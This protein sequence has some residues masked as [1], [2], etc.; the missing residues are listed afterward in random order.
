[1]I[2]LT[3]RLVVFAM[4]N[5][6][7]GW[8]YLPA[9]P[10]MGDAIFTREDPVK[11]VPPT[12]RNNV[13]TW[14]LCNDILDDPTQTSWSALV[15][16]LGCNP[17]FASNLNAVNFCTVDHHNTAFYDNA[18]AA[19]QNKGS[20]T[21]GKCAEK[22][23]VDWLEACV[24]SKCNPARAK[25][26]TSSCPL[27]REAVRAQ[28][29]MEKEKM[30]VL[31]RVQSFKPPNVQQSVNA[32]GEVQSYKES[33]SNFELPDVRDNELTGKNVNLCPPE[34]MAEK[35]LA[36]SGA[37]KKTCLILADAMYMAVEIIPQ[38]TNTVRVKLH[39]FTNVPMAAI[40][41]E[42]VGLKPE[43]S[44]NLHLSAIMGEVTGL[45]AIKVQVWPEQFVSLKVT[46]IFSHKEMLCRSLKNTGDSIK[47]CAV[48][49]PPSGTNTEY[50]LSLNLF[51]QDETSYKLPIAS[52]DPTS[53]VLAVA[54]GPRFESEF[55]SIANLLEEGYNDD[56]SPLAG[57]GKFCAKIITGAFCDF[58]GGDTAC[59]PFRNAQCMQGEMLY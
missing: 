8:N 47:V 28:I 59:E 1:M 57:E 12:F 11:S 48:F 16:P 45:P 58:A 40:A 20:V 22:T 55:G 46:Y 37:I 26:F 23:Y 43:I 27:G 42:Q 41:A 29:M 2:I 9:S 21:M 6:F 14:V 17:D 10:C 49:S 4:P 5:M 24:E 54:S 33:V 34:W 35:G 44:I 52:V 7:A 19:I 13:R 39:L 38:S 15:E 51:L 30:N 31:S 53:G 50:G 56:I 18:L 3:G 32:L 36:T 25:D